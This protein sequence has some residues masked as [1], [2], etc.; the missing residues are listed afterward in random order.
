MPK[1]PISLPFYIPE[2]GKGYPFRAELPCIDHYR[3][4]PHGSTSIVNQ[5][6]VLTELG[7]KTN[8]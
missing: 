3:E 8:K 5:V 7:S 2:A 4:Y 6:T 1:W